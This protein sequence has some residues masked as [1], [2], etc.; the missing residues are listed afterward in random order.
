MRQRRRVDSHG[1]MATSASL[2]TATTTNPTTH[3]TTSSSSQTAQFGSRS[4]F[5]VWRGYKRE[6]RSQH[7]YRVDGE[8]VRSGGQSEWMCFSPTNRRCTSWNRG[9]YRAGRFSPT[10]SRTEAKACAIAAFTSMPEQE[11]RTVCAAT[12]QQLV[13]QNGQPV[14]MRLRFQCPRAAYRRINCDV[15]Q[16]LLADFKETDYSWRRVSRCT[17]STSTQGEGG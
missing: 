17:P 10:T 2:P 5:G 8:T 6:P 12:R 3:Q 1:T 14:W 7:V 9:T 15:R 16:C 13:R 4:C 11:R